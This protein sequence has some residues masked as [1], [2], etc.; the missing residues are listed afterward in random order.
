M[1][2]FLRFISNCIIVSGLIMEPA[3]AHSISIDIQD[4][5]QFLDA[6]S[7]AEASG[8]STKMVLRN[9]I[10]LDQSITIPNNVAL[11]ALKRS[12]I[13][14]SSQKSM[15]LYGSMP[16]S[17]TPVF[18]G[19]GTVI[20]KNNSTTTISPIWFFVPNGNPDDDNHFQAF[21]DSV[22]ESGLTGVIPP[23]FTAIIKNNLFLYGS[24]SISCSKNNNSPSMIVIDANFNTNSPSSPYWINLGINRR[25]GVESTWHGSITG[26]HFISK[27]YSQF[28]YALFIHSAN[29]FSIRHNVF[30]WRNL[31]DNTIPMASIEGF[32]DSKW[33]VTPGVRSNGT[34]S[35]NK[36][37]HN[38]D[39]IGGEGFG[40]NTAHNIEFSNNLVHGVGDDPIG[41][42]GVDG[43]TIKNNV[44]FTTDG[45][46]LYDNSNNVVIKN[47]Y[48]ERIAGGRS[49][50]Y[51]SGG[52]YIWG[53]I[54]DGLSSYPTPT[55][56]LIDQNTIKIPAEISSSTYAIRLI[57]NRN[58]TVINNVIIN[59]SPNQKT[60]CISAEA[61][62]YPKWEDPTGQDS[63]HIA[64]PRNILIQGNNCRGNFPMSIGHSGN[65]SDLIGPFAFIRN[66]AKSYQIFA[67]NSKNDPI[68]PPKKE[69]SLNRP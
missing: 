16:L 6:L 59:N 27:P 12:S 18:S 14:I 31:H 64:R 10:K 62:L 39:N 35:N 4:S 67:P 26:C 63:D 49:K 51:Y 24:G 65:V 45:R 33:L 20:F 41:A 44:L 50:K 61:Q 46:I 60:L 3:V 66:K 38:Q 69:R 21:L 30:D 22:S 13:Y 55:N 11:I 57:G 23:R 52:G 28:N 68:I 40:I 48:I 17:N 29:G 1:P 9:S 36:I 56:I 34:I 32:N 42:H 2:S 25:L 15:I 58:A 8:N 19:P 54:D 53:G 5:T 47:N 43:L 7:R 37:F